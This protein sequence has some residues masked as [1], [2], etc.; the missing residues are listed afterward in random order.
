MGLAGTGIAR[1]SDRFISHA[2]LAP[3]VCPVWDFAAPFQVAKWRSAHL[4]PPHMGAEAPK[5]HTALSGP[6]MLS[7][8]PSAKI[9]KKK[10]GGGTALPLLDPLPHLVLLQY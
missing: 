9:Q 6:A 3:T 5:F 7:A 2:V 1:Y 4:A 10:K 8:N